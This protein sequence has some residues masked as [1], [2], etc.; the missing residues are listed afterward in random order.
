MT[1]PTGSTRIAQ[2][3]TYLMCKPTHFT[4]SYRINPWMEPANP[5]DTQLAV[6]QWQ[7]LY[8]TYLDLG[9]EV[10]L[11]DPVEGLPDMVY[12]ANGGFVIDGVAYG[13]KFRFAERAGEEQPFM[14]WFREN[15]LTVVEP[16][17][18][19]EGEGD[20]LLAGDIILA[21]T[22][23]RSTGDSHREVAEVF[24]REVVSLTLTDPRFYHLDTAISVLDPVQG[25]G[26]VE[27]ANIAYLPTA[28]DAAS[29]ATLQRLFP[30]AIEVSDADGA[31][32]GLNS[33]SDGRNVFISPRATGFEAQLRERGYNPVLVDLSEL[34]LGGG[35]IKCCT[36]EIR[37]SA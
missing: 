8:D 20:F 16:R 30:E 11:I 32:F 29:R 23:F 10:Q 2:H 5:T 9:H 22:G 13:P 6:D 27:R 3:R 7:A 36:L 31:V 34:L 1:H 28:F 15:G 17:E 35:G 21:G 33:A 18:T 25:P 24:D 26:G 19:N 12:T 4:V 37:R 14:T